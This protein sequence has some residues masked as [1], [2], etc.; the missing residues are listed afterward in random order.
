MAIA[1]VGMAHII[2]GNILVT[3][4]RTTTNHNFLDRYYDF[5]S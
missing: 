1:M 3:K 4:K 5:K 2:T